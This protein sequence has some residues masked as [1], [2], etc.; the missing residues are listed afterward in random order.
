MSE[1]YDVEKAENQQ[2]EEGFNWH[3]KQTVKGASLTFG[4]VLTYF[5]LGR[6]F[7]G[8]SKDNKPIA[9]LDLG[10]S[11]SILD[12]LYLPGVVKNNTATVLDQLNNPK[13]P[14]SKKIII[15]PKL[16][17]HK[18]AIGDQFQASTYAS[19]KSDPDITPLENGNYVEVWASY[20]QDTDY[21]G[22][23]FQIFGSDGSK[24]GIEV[25]ANTET[26]RD[27]DHPAVIDLKNN[28]FLVVWQSYNQD[29]IPNGQKKSNDLS[30]HCLS[31]LPSHR[32]RRNQM[33]TVTIHNYVHSISANTVYVLSNTY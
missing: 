13:Q 31:L 2:S 21:D 29:D 10:K 16:K 22:V 24:I 32:Q 20:D 11:A 28:T 15:R 27:Q 12:D 19:G 30:E 14:A 3:A 25:Q 5:L 6:W 33:L 26:S 23:F 9:P 17:L 7:R 1:E 18:R 4:G 8:E